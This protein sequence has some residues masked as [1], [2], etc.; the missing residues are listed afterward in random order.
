M[1]DYSKMGRDELLAIVEDLTRSKF[2]VTYPSDIG[3][4]LCDDIGHFTQEHYVV[5]VMNTQNEIL[6]QKVINIGTVNR[7]VVDTATLARTL[8]AN[9]LT[10]GFFTAH[11][12]PS[13][14][15]N[16]SAE[17]NNVRQK[18]AEIAKLFHLNYL[19]DFIVSRVGFWSAAQ[20]GEMPN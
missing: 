4:K 2:S 5:V 3:S 8:L 12:H 1:M 7:S 9:P 20:S 16:P 17:D 11:N 14:S 13:G 6:E 19:D 15:L 18:V 10:A